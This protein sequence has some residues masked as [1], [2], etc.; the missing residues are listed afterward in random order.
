[1][2]RSQKILSIARLSVAISLKFLHCIQVRSEESLSINRLIREGDSVLPHPLSFPRNRGNL[3]EPNGWSCILRQ[4]A[5]SHASRKPNH[6][7]PDDGFRAPGARNRSGISF[8]LPLHGANMRL[9]PV[10]FVGWAQRSRERTAT[11]IEIPLQVSTSLLPRDI[12]FV[13]R[14]IGNRRI[15]EILSAT[16]DSHTDRRSPYSPDVS[17]LIPPHIVTKL[18]AG[19]T[20]HAVGS[21]QSGPLSDPSAT[22]PSCFR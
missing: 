8:P 3:R 22:S 15:T 12:S 2:P 4:R 1:M 11:A 14:A 20:D 13:Q 17:F 19:Y 21:T 5:T 7:A 10:I 9:C 18:V 6:T 16:T